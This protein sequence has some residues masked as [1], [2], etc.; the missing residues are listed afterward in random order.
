MINIIIFLLF[1]YKLRLDHL[2]I[3]RI[4][5]FRDLIQ[6]YIKKKQITVYYIWQ[7]KKYIFLDIIKSW[8]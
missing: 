5:L 3:A 1:V 2:D 6:E 4:K 8:R 7:E